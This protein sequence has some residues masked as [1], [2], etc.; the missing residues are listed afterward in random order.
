[1]KY[2]TFRTEGFDDGDRVPL[3]LEQLYAKLVVREEL[4]DPAIE[5]WIM[6]A[7]TIEVTDD[8]E[9]EEFRTRM[10]AFVD[11][12]DERFI[13][14]HRCAQTLKEGLEPDE[15]WFRKGLPKDFVIPTLESNS[16]KIQAHM[17]NVIADEEAGIKNTSVVLISW[18]QLPKE[19]RLELKDRLDA[20]W[21]NDVFIELHTE[22]P[23][24][25]LANYERTRQH[26]IERWDAKPDDI[27]NEDTL[28]KIMDGGAF[29]SEV[30]RILKLFPNF[31]PRNP[32]TVLLDVRW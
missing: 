1:M 31:K 20:S 4:K 26:I 11:G 25:V 13:N 2:F 3:L 18:S 24:R 28:L 7:F 27:T 12:E 15:Y 29:D 16:A 8:T 5:S 10:E 23:T 32:T 19:L 14:M 21:R 22:V 30:Y 17:D 6:D 9:L